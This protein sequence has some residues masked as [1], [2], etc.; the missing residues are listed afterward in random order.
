MFKFGIVVEY[1][2]C[3]FSTTTPTFA[4]EERMKS[5]PMPMASC[6]FD[7]QNQFWHTLSNAADLPSIS[8]VIL[9]TECIQ[10][11]YFFL[12][13]DGRNVSLNNIMFPPLNAAIIFCNRSCNLSALFT[14]A[15]LL[16]MRESTL[17]RHDYTLRTQLESK[18]RVCVS[19]VWNGETGLPSVVFFTD[20][21]EDSIRKSIC[22]S[23]T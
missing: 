16:T 23:K 3:I 20:V 13:N 1:L 22:F 10:N 12:R 2:S 18:I 11:M 8:H 5:E 21:A 4:T 14:N 7:Y 19:L 9:A 15:F 6:I 17:L